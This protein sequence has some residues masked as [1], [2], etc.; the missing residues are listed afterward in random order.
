MKVAQGELSLPEALKQLPEKPM[1]TTQQR[2]KCKPKSG[3]K[4]DALREELRLANERNYSTI[5]AQVNTLLLLLAEPLHLSEH[6]VMLMEQ[7]AA[8]F[9]TRIA[10]LT[11][12]QK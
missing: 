6:E 4:A 7:L 9:A 11:G 10:Q 8:Q 12:E 1:P 5:E 3:P 2:V